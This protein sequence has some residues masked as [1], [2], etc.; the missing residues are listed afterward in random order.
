MTKEQKQARINVLKAEL[1]ILY[2]MWKLKPDVSIP[3]VV[4]RAMKANAIILEIYTIQSQPMPKFKK[5]LAIVGD[6][7]QKEI[8]LNDKRRTVK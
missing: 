8:I 7:S 3:E 2:M 4:V 6:K 5:G 1:C